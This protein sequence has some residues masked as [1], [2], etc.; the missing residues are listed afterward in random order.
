MWRRRATAPHA[1]EN[2]GLSHPTRPTIGESHRSLVGS[3]RGGRLPSWRSARAVAALVTIPFEQGAPQRPG[4]QLALRASPAQSPRACERLRT[5]A[6]SGRSQ[7]LSGLGQVGC[8]Y[9]GERHG[10]PWRR[11]VFRSAGQM[12]LSWAAPRHRC[13]SS[14]A[15]H[16]VD[17]GAGYRSHKLS[18]DLLC[19][20]FDPSLHSQTR[21]CC[22]ES[23]RAMFPTSAAQVR[24]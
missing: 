5:A 12:Q 1:I 17:R 16:V 2:R 10:G 19:K 20:A 21:R 14:E 15:G 11:A 9:R 23:R 3:V 4:R 22:E 6:G 7:A 8:L 13:C 18:S 24:C